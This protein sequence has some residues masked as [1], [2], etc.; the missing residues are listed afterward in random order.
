MLLLVSKDLDRSKGL[1]LTNPGLIGG[2]GGVFNIENVKSCLTLLPHGLQ[3]V[4]VLCPWEFSG[5]DTG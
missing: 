4:R 1:R 5:R 3:P 2:G